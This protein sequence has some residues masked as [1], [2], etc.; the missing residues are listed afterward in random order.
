[1]VLVAVAGG[2]GA[3][4]VGDEYKVILDEV[5][6]LLLA[7]LKIYNLTCYFFI[8]YGIYYYILNIH[9]VFNFNAMCF[10][11]FYQREDEALILVVL[12]ETK[13]AE[14]RQSVD[15]MY[16]TAQI[17]LHFKCA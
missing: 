9:T 7:T 15:V 3:A 6:C 12:R 1:M 8:A 2:V 16:I 17:T 13:C 10:K 4:S 5:D 11:V 14:I